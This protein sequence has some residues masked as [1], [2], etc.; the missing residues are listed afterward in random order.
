MFGLALR[1]IEEHN[2]RSTLHSLA[3]RRETDPA[4]LRLPSPDDPA[5]VYRRLLAIDTCK[6]RQIWPH[7]NINIRKVRFSDG[8]RETLKM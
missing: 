4:S 1:G 3:T 2:Q 7:R 6:G 8:R 5:P